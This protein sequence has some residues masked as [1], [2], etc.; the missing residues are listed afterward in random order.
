V[1]KARSGAI[2]SRA[3]RR[4]LRAVLHWSEENFGEAASV[5]YL[6]LIL[7]AIRDV[8][9]DSDRPGS[10]ERLDL[11]IPSAKTCHMSF[12]RTRVRGA[13]VKS[14]RHFLIYRRRRDG[15][16]EISRILHDARDLADV[17]MG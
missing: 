6:E 5:R 9:S 13:R 2:L 15:M 8:G 16:V 1:A 14:P 17:T 11:A 12:S 7:Q 10:F 4:D 3:A